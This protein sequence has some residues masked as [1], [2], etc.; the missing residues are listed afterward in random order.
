MD[1]QQW[2]SLCDGCGRCCLVKLWH[3]T[4]VKHSKVGCRLLDVKTA[5]CTNYDNRQQMVK[6]CRKVTLDNIHTPGLLPDTCAYVLLGQGKPLYD[7]H[8]LV[9]GSRDTVITSG[10]SVVGWAEVNENNV[11]SAQ[12]H[13]YLIDIID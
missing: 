9:S 1:E 8:H 2:E 7:W 5:R 3:G 4:D 10:S 6:N 13:K 12:M 11:S